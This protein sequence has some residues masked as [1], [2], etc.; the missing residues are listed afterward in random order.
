MNFIIGRKP[1]ARLAIRT[2]AG[3]SEK[4]RTKSNT[5]YRKGRNFS[6]CV[7]EIYELVCLALCSGYEG[8][9]CLYNPE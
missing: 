2:R 5:C 8:S 9:T 1:S 6:H 7:R 4:F 3:S